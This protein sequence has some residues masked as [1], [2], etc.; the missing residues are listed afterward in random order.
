MLVSQK[1]LLPV[2]K[3]VIFLEVQT[4]PI[5]SDNYDQPL[6]NSPSRPQLKQPTPQEEDDF[7]R[8]VDKL[9]RMAKSPA[10]NHKP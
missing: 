1:L 7:D 9:R 4:E 3:R 6:I 10:T 5:F 2:I 8:N